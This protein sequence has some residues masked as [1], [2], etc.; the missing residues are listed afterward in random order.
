MSTPTDTATL[1]VEADVQ[2]NP[3]RLSEPCIVRVRLTN[4]SDDPVRLNT[5]LAVGYR[6]R[7]DREV[8]AEVY[9]P[10]TDE[11]VS[12][13]AQLYQ[14][15]PAAAEDYTTLAPGE[16]VNASFDLLNWYDLPGPGDYE[17]VVVYDSDSVPGAPPEDAPTGPVA[18]PRIPF[19]VQS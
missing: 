19:T 10:G 3:V 7:D 1:H 12:R 6:E 4:A 16:S 9:V 5:R 8:F 2:P 14:R 15:D 13:P 11:V 17:V 18:S